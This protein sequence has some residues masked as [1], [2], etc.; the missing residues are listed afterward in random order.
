MIISD[1][2][3]ELNECQN[4]A[5]NEKIVDAKTIIG[6]KIVDKEL[7]ASTQQNADKKHKKQGSLTESQPH[8][9]MK[10]SSLDN[11]KEKLHKIH[12]ERSIIAEKLKESLQEFTKENASL[13]RN[14]KESKEEVDTLISTNKLLRKVCVTP[15]CSQYLAN[16]LIN[17][18]QMSNFSDKLIL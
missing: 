18:Y 3:Q 14:M 13:R 8:M 11:M 5:Q 1:V 2:L 7:S 16:L 17:I 6:E 10:L 4:T 12:S 9:P 15:A